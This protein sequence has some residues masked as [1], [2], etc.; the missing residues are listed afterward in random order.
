LHL[1][2]AC[3]STITPHEIE[4]CIQEHGIELSTEQ[5]DDQQ[6]TAL[7]ILC[8]NPNVTGGAIRFYLQLSPETAANVQDG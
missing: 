1:H 3:S 8:A 4:V 5:V 6:M 7:H 2:E